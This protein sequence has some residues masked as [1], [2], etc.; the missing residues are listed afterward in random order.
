MINSFGFFVAIAFMVAGWILSMELTRKEK[1]GLFVFTEQTITVGG[2]VS[3]TDWLIT[4]FLGFIFGYKFIGAFLLPDVFRDPQAFI[5]SAEGHPLAGLL[6]GGI[7]VFLKYR[8]NK[9]E[10]IF[11]S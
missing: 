1:Q 6:V 11:D 4:F 8:E 3:T 5:F 10:S 9:K 2:P 7:M